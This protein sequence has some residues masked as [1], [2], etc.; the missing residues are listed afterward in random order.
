MPELRQD[1][2]CGEWIVISTERGLRPELFRS[3]EKPGLRARHCPACPFCEGNES[4]TL[5]EVWALRSGTPP[6]GPGW[7][8][9][10]VPNKFAALVPRGDFRRHSELNFF[11]KAEGVGYH[12]VIIETPRHDLDLGTMPEADVEAVVRAYRARHAELR[13]DPRVE[14]VIIFRNHGKSAGTSVDHAHSQ[15]IATPVVPNLVRERYEAAVS[16]YDDTGRVLLADILEKELEMGSRVV[17]END[18][19]AAFQPF[20]PRQPFETWIVPRSMAP[21]FASITDAQCRSL[22]K[23]LRR[24]LYRLYTGLNDPDYNLVIH[25]AS[26]RDE[27]QPYYAWHLQVLPHITTPAGFE[28]GSGMYISTMLPEQTAAYMRKIEVAEAPS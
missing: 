4:E 14:A 11:R 7:R 15:L 18:A 28:I 22:A 9:R 6:N 27:N 17:D 2:A 3:G 25:T 16:Y 1:P 10:V 24:T 12:E 21:S 8:L 13:L 19:F 23:I 26:L 5:P 20:A